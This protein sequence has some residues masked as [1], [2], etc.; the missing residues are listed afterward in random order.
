M[1][2]LHSHKSFKWTYILVFFNPSFN[3]DYNIL[4]SKPNKRSVFHFFCE[5]SDLYKAIDKNAK[6]LLNFSLNGTPYINRPYSLHFGL[7]GS[8]TPLLLFHIEQSKRLQNV[9]PN[10]FL[11]K[12]TTY[13]LASI[14]A[15]IF[16]SR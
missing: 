1:C 11:G 2:H 13:V 5:T 8:L 4:N 3:V 10:Y 15:I 16:F 9:N 7:N 14:T 12:L 6:Q